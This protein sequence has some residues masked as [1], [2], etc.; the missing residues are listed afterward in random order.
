MA[1]G[2]EPLIAFRE[3]R[4]IGNNVDQIAHALNAAAQAGLYLPC[5]GDSVQKAAEIVKYEMRRVVVVITGNFA[6][7]SLLDAERVTAA[8]G[9]VEQAATQAQLTK[10]SARGVSGGGRSVLQTSRLSVFTSSK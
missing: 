8:P 7:W 6:Y 5:Q 3:L 1:G 10:S 4:A 9:D 2:A